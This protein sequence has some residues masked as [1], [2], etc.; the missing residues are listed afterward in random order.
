MFLGEK[1]R[2]ARFRT[3]LARVNRGD[4]VRKHSRGNAA[5]A[6]SLLDNHR[7]DAQVVTARIVRCHRLL[8][9][10]VP[11]RNC[12]AHKTYDLVRAGILAHKEKLR[13]VREPKFQALRGRRFVR[14]IAR[15]L[16]GFDSRQV[17]RLR[18][19]ECELSDTAAAHT[20][21]T[22]RHHRHCAPTQSRAHRPRPRR[23][24][25]RS[26]AVRGRF[27]GAAKGGQL[28]GG[29]RGTTHERRSRRGA[30]STTQRAPP[31]R[32]QR[33]RRRAR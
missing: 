19:P 13:G 25:P 33:L 3:V 32:R 2:Q 9:E 18:P 7:V 5:P 24:V 10:R 31:R 16:Q 15:R 6:A 28:R 29:T 12:G 23:L 4:V 14:R 1:R 20:M 17:A 11:A 30:H 27:I 8:S 26:C 22:L 21:C